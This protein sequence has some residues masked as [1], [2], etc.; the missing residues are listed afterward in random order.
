MTREDERLREEFARLRRSDA[1]RAPSFEALRRPPRAR[2]I[3]P[4]IRALVPLMLVAAAAAMLLF[5]QKDIAPTGTPMATAPPADVVDQ[6]AL[7]DTTQGPLPLDFLLRTDVV[8]TQF[9]SSV[10][11][12]DSDFLLRSHAPLP[13][14]SP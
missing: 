8:S 13:G 9:R 11:G 12:A 5:L 14:T 4:A 10:T 1:R 3:R 7:A 6:M 2:P